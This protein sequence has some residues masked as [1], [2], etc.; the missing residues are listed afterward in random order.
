MTQLYEGIPNSHE[1]NALYN[2]LIIFGCLVY[3]QST[4]IGLMT[5]N[6]EIKMK[7]EIFQQEMQL[8]SGTLFSFLR[9]DQ[10][11]VVYLILLKWAK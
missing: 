4:H 1:I 8:K 11:L 6:N 9:Y 10:Q 7:L 2:P 3:L 5:E